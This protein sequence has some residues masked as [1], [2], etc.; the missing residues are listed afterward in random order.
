MHGGGNPQAGLKGRQGRAGMYV[1]IARQHIRLGKRSTVNNPICLA[2]RAAGFRD[3][4]TDGY[5]LELRELG[6]IWHLDLLPLRVKQW[7]LAWL[8][9]KK[10]KPMRFLVR[11]WSTPLNPPRRRR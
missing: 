3:A 5:W 4:R 9:G 8:K 1:D 2:L 10:V 11:G 6:G 7:G